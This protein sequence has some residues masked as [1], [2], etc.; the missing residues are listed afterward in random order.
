MNTQRLYQCPQTLNRD[1]VLSRTKM[2]QP[3]QNALQGVYTRQLF[4]R[5]SRRAPVLFERPRYVH[6][7]DW[8]LAEFIE[9]RFSHV[10]LTRQ[11]RPA[12][13]TVCT[14]C[15]GRQQPA[16]PMLYTLFCYICE[17]RIHS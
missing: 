9:Y 1:T 2:Q 3:L 11:E 7:N 6:N 10:S 16:W 4:L 13:T 17:Y 14:C 12:F 8:R 15:T 5:C